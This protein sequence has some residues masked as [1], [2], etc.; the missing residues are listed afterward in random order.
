MKKKIYNI[1]N[2]FFCSD[3]HFGHRG[4]LKYREGFSSLEEMEEVMI[5]NWNNTVS[6][7]SDVFFLGDFA[8]TSSIERITNYRNRL[9]GRI[10]LLTGNHDSQNRFDREV[11][12]NLFESVDDMLTIHVGTSKDDKQ[13]VVLCHYP[14]ED[15]NG[16]Q[17]D[18]IHLHGHC[19][20]PFEV[21]II[22]NRY[23]VCM[24]QIDY[25]PRKL[26]EILI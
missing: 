3:L 16:K 20:N 23:N 22:K 15:W 6:E 12:E 5:K 18:S 13:R 19:H 7:D 1:D 9:N 2:T 10:H 8:M 4:M 11:I 25:T 26:N 24:E 14:I 17:A 21:T